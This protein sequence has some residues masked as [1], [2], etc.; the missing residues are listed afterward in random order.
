MREVLSC[1][2]IVG[3]Y[4]IGSPKMLHNFGSIKLFIFPMLQKQFGFLS[5]APCKVVA[6]NFIFFTFGIRAMLLFLIT[7]C[8]VISFFNYIDSFCFLL[9][10][11]LQAT[12]FSFC[13]C[14]Q[15]QIKKQQWLLLQKLEEQ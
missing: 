14:A 10:L 2:N 11:K 1:M 3:I 13:F 15:K 5:F 4:N 6:L 7:L 9:L 8:Q 12:S